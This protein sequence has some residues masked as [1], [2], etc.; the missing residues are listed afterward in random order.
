MRP[1]SPTGPLAKAGCQVG[2]EVIFVDGDCGARMACGRIGK[3]PAMSC[4]FLHHL[5]PVLPIFT[6]LRKTRDAVMS[7]MALELIRKAKAEGWKTLDLGNTGIVGEVPAEIWELEE[8]EELILSDKWPEWKQGEYSYQKSRN[9]GSKNCIS[10]FPLSPK[11]Q[12]GN[13]KPLFSKSK[14]SKSV[15]LPALGLH[16]RLKYLVLSG[17]LISDIEAIGSLKELQHLNVENTKI[18]ELNSIALLLQLNYLDLSH[19]E[20]EDLKP[21]AGLHALQHLSLS[22][23][24]VWDLSPLRDLYN[25]QYLFLVST[26][27]LSIDS[28]AG[29]NALVYV[30][31]GGATISD[32]GAL[33]KL[34]FLE[35]LLL[36]G[37]SVIDLQPL[38]QLQNLRHL[39][40]HGTQVKQQQRELI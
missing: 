8:L 7:E 34:N 18:S 13:Q 25:L 3:A 12:L 16:N 24:S 19:T 26:K 20:V 22:F 14:K 5:C 31:L 33:S 27:I 28:I 39:Y 6:G 30:N 32:I 9:K 1:F 11:F 17:T 21:L 10:I 23:T 2:R 29:L 38:S 37:T 35:K 40:L 15:D 4:I 36:S